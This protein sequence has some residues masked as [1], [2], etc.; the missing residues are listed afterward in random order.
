M[1]MLTK[2]ES[3]IAE[4][5]AS[6]LINDGLVC[7]EELEWYLREGVSSIFRIKSDAHYFE[8]EDY[9]LEVV[10]RRRKVVKVTD[11]IEN[12]VFRFRNIAEA[13]RELDITYHKVS[14]VISAGY[15]L[16]DRYRLEYARATI[17]EMIV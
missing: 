17:K 12:K 5:L 7:G 3:K 9:V 16:F 15:L 6:D 14:T 2:W 13:A 11:V 1:K 10:E 8:F 4:E